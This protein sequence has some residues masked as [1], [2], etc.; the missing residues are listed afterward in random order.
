[1]LQMEVALFIPATVEYRCW[2]I[3]VQW[4]A[5]EKEARRKQVQTIKYLM[6]MCK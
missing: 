6:V 4:K 3:V 5:T 2:N 1:M